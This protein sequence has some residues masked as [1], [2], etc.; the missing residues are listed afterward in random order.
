MEHLGLPSSEEEYLW[1]HQV[2]LDKH[3][4]YLRLYPEAEDV[5]Q[6]L[7]EKG[8]HI[9]LISDIDHDFMID[10]LTRLGIIEYFNAL[11]SSEE[12]GV[13][14]P[15]PHIFQL[16]LS[17]AQYTG[18]ESI[19]IGDNLERDVIGAQNMGMTAIW[20]PNTSD[21]SSDVPDYTIRNMS[22]ILGIL[23]NFGISLDE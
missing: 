20:Y 12:A 14:K 15:D 9:G 11:T 7:W 19:H 6:A 1:F 8:L 18:P 23:R 5:L 3:H 17:K 2:Y 13:W 22:E 16:A 10:T 4:T 21:A